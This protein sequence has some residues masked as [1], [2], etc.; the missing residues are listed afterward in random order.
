MLAV[1]LSAGFGAG[2]S[3]AIWNAQHVSADEARDIAAQAVN[4]YDHG[5][6]DA[7]AEQRLGDD[8]VR[9]PARGVAYSIARIER[10]RAADHGQLVAIGETTARIE[11]LVRAQY[12]WQVRLVASDAEP[13]RTRKMAAANAAVGRYEREIAHGKAPDDAAR[14]A[15]SVNPYSLR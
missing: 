2:G 8:V 3:F 10:D 4:R 9:A 13:N 14:M 15:L 11:Q 1:V 12:A 5:T 7:L 6:A